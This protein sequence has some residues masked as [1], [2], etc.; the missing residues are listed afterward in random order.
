MEAKGSQTYHDNFTKHTTFSDASSASRASAQSQ[1]G[2]LI[3]AASKQIGEWQSSLVS[4]LMWY[5]RKIARVAGS[6]LASETYAPSGS[7]DLLSCCGFSGT[8]FVNPVQPGK[9]LG[10]ETCRCQCPGAFAVVDCK[11]LHDLSQKTTIFLYL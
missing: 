11:G 4:P 8:G 2:C 5:C 10:P 3:L 1:K 6:T 9:T 7:V